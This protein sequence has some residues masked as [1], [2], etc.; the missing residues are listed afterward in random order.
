[1]TASDST[2]YIDLPEKRL[3]RTDEAARLLGVSRKTI[4]HWCSNGD[5]KFIRIGRGNIR[6]DRDCLIKIIS[7]SE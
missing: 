2:S 4:Y 3:F 1:M 7:V 6:I 5:L